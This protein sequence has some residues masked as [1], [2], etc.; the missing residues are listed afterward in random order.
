M[1]NNKSLGNNSLKKEIYK[2]FWDELK[3]IFVDS[4]TE[5]KEKTSQRQA[6]I[7]LIGKNIYILCSF[8]LVLKGKTG[9]EIPKSLKL[10]FLANHFALSDA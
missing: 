3:E 1:P 2:T 7:K 9:K 5:A 10:D 4:L 8:R 6:I